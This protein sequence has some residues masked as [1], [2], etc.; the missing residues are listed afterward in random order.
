MHCSAVRPVL[1]LSSQTLYVRAL[2]KLGR[3]ALARRALRR[4][5]MCSSVGVTKGWGGASSSRAPAP[6]EMCQVFPL[7]AFLGLQEPSVS[8]ACG[9]CCLVAKSRWTLLQTPW[10]VARQ[11]P[12]SMGFRSQEYWSGWLFACSATQT[13]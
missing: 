1:R 6:G 4:S 11:A 10:T 9:Y 5:L 3:G 8:F 7:T 12:M 2:C 13:S